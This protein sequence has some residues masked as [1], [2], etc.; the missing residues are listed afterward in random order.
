MR[1]AERLQS[2]R[3]VCRIGLSRVEAGL[4]LGA[5]FA[6]STERPSAGGSLGPLADVRG[7]AGAAQATT[8]VLPDE[9]E[10]GVMM[11]AGSRRPP[12]P[13]R[14]RAGFSTPPPPWVFG[15]LL[16]GPK[17]FDP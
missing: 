6:R 2:N 16:R 7:L 8:C 1:R 17:W 11:V 4:L 15:L 12:L 3:T 10:P 14:R 9:E 13:L 5:R